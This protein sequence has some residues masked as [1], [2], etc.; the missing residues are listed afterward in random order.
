MSITSD[1]EEKDKTVPYVKLNVEGKLSK[2]KRDECREIIREIKNFGVNQRQILYIIQLLSL[3][4]ENTDIMKALTTTIGRHRDLIPVVAE[5][6]NDIEEQQ[7]QKTT[8]TITKKP[9][10]IIPGC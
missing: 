8:T 6:D 10:L 7:Q 9:R 2:K 5:E 1:E 4:L 3:E